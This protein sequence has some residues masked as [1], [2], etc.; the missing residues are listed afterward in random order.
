MQDF[1]GKIKDLD[2]FKPSTI[3]K[4]ASERMVKNILSGNNNTEDKNKTNVRK[5]KGSV[6]LPEAAHLTWEKNLK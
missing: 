4:E 1:F 3:N 5:L 2:T 6:P